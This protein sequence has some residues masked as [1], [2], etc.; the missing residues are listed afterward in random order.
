[1]SKINFVVVALLPMVFIAGCIDITKDGPRF[2]VDPAAADEGFVMPGA[3][4]IDLVEKMAAHRSAYRAA[5]RELEDYYAS[6]GD[7]TK[8]RWAQKELDSLVQYRYLMPAETARADLAATDSIEQADVLFEEALQI[9][10][11]A[12]RLVVISDKA[13]MRVALRK[14]NELIAAYPSSDKIDDAAYRAGQVHEYFKDYEIAAV[15]YQRAV[16]WDENTPYPARFKAAYVLDKFLHMR[17]EAMT[18]YR[19]ACQKEARFPGNI[20]Y[21][22]KRISE[23]TKSEIDA[24]K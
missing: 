17:K 22:K 18:F 20:E 19:L 12:R 21:A 11:K 15:Y 23:M 13:E 10:M 2:Q 4:Q 8:L 1:M 3:A 14:F 24:L 16:Q 7:A 9:Y 5:L 6:S